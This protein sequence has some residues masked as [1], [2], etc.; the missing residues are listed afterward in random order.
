MPTF[1]TYAGEA[2]YI[3]SP[4]V[5]SSTCIYPSVRRI[6]FPLRRHPIRPMLFY[7]PIPRHQNPA[8]YPERNVNSINR[9]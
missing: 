6:T 2:S 1:G 5:S 8:P 4:E 9:N 7:D 3:Q